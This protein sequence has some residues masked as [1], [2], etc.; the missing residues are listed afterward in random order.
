VRSLRAAPALAIALTLA[1]LGCGTAP[2]PQPPPPPRSPGPAS[3]LRVGPPPPPRLPSGHS[4]R[5]LGRLPWVGSL[6]GRLA[7]GPWG[8]A[9]LSRDSA[10]VRWPRPRAATLPLYE[11]EP[12]A[13]R[14]AA[15]DTL[16]LDSLALWSARAA[17]PE[18]REPALLHWSELLALDGDTL[19]ADSLL[20]LDDLRVSVWAWTA[21]Q[22]R[23]RLALARGDTLAAD[24]LLRSADTRGWP[25]A[26]LSAWSV[27]IARL[28]AARGDTTRALAA[29]RLT[30]RR[31]PGL[32]AGSEG[33][34]LTETMLAARGDSLDVVESK[35]AAEVEA[36]RGS[37]A[38]AA[39]RLARLAPRVEGEERGRVALRDAEL[40]RRARAFESARHAA[41]TARAAAADSAW[42]ARVDLER[43]RIMRDSGRSDSAV[44]AYARVARLAR[45]ATREVALWERAR[46]L[47]DDGRFEAAADAFER[48]LGNGTRRAEARFLAGLMAYAAGRRDTA[49]A[50]WAG[51]TLESARFWRGVEL[52]RCG[53]PR[54]DS[55]LRGLAA[56]PGY[57]FYRAAARDTL[58][59]RGLPDSIAPATP[60]LDSGLARREQALARGGLVDEALLIASR[61][62]ARDARLTG[63]SDSTTA[64]DPLAG[65]SVAWLAGRPPAVVG[66]ALEAQRQSG[67]LPAELQWPIVP[68]AYPPAFDSLV[69]AAADSCGIEPALLLATMR[70]ESR[71]DPAARSISNAAGLMQLLPAAAGDAARWAHEPPPT[72]STLIDPASSL[73]LGARYLARLV[74]RFD[75]HVAVALSAYNAGPSTVPP[76]WRELIARG[77][78]ALFCEFASN[79]DAQD[80]ARRILGYRQAYRELAPRLSR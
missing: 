2:P 60:R 49:L 80:Y 30:M 26:E 72:D 59:V 33:L 78:E 8:L 25:D 4:G 77:G 34:R 16:V 67:D 9:E 36:L 63:A 50:R 5:H 12:E 37:F 73:K 11:F 45:G 64:L 65:A 51:D 10:G 28:A 52:R 57:L 24:S 27:A 47:Q 61:A 15:G 69:V 55:L 22:A 39:R 71:F 56:L 38:A 46:E 23:E 19:R 32:A 35:M 48:V 70:Q 74:A 53:D 79:A 13:V 29:A 68:W 76:F 7:A 54:G 1:P 58:G 14:R 43:A 21:L 66:F 17:K 6:P 44:A 75:G 42:R 62:A 20:R 41:A 3:E 18:W 31:F 40:A